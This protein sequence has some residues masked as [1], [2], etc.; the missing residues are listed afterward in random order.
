MISFVYV[1]GSVSQLDRV[2]GQ[3]ESTYRIEY[4]DGRIQQNSEA[5]RR[6]MSGR[7]ARVAVANA[8]SNSS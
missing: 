8:P 7:H 2:E 6:E 3:N 5:W 4:S 1:R